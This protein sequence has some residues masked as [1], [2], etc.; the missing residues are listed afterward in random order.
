MRFRGTEKKKSRISIRVTVPDVYPLNSSPYYL[1]EYR[2]IF[3]QQILV[4]TSRPKEFRIQSYF[5]GTP[6]TFNPLP[7]YKQYL[8]KMT[9]HPTSLH[10]PGQTLRAPGG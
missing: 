1:S 2:K 7:I 9:Q 6:E 3:T 8:K 10:R 5:Y 4:L